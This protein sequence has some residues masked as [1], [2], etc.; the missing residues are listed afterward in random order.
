MLETALFLFGSSLFAAALLL[1]V[2][3]RD[4]KCQAEQPEIG[5]AFDAKAI[6]PKIQKVRENYVAQ[7]QARDASHAFHDQLLVLACQ[8]VKSLN[9]FKAKAASVSFHVEE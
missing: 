5:V 2:R 9:F 3:R 8:A 6:G 4:A 7:L 1:R